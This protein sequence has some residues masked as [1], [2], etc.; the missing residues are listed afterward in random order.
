MTVL[1]AFKIVFLI[2]ALVGFVVIFGAPLIILHGKKDA[3]VRRRRLAVK[4][5]LIGVII[6]SVGL[7]VVII[8][9]NF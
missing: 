1:M 6:A 7:L 3:D 4:T 9:S 5:R 8:L 2:V